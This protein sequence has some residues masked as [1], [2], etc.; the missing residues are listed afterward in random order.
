[1][2]LNDD[3]TAVVAQNTSVVASAEQAISGLFSEVNSLTA[4]LAAG[5]IDVPTFQAQIQ[6]LQTN[7]SGLAAAIT[8]NTPAAPAATLPA[9]SN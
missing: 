3:L 2:S 6:Q 9:S 8:A 1:M 4:Q 5:Q 7:N